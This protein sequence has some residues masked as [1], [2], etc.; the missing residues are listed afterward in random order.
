[1]EVVA[2]GATGSSPAA[3]PERTAGAASPRSLTTGAASLSSLPARV[4]LGLPAL[5][6]LGHVG[7]VYY[8]A[9]SRIGYPFELEWLEGGVLASVQEVLAGRPIFVKP[10]LEY[11]PFLYTPLYDYV[12]AAAA[13]AFGA[14]FTTLRALTLLCTTF[15]LLGLAWQQWRAGEGLG[16]TLLAPGF[17][18]AAFVPTATFYDVARGDVMCVALLF[19]GFLVVRFREGWVAALSG[20]VLCGLAVFTKQPAAAVGAAIGLGV[21]LRRTR[22]GVAFLAAFLVVAGGLCIAEQ[23]RSGGWFSYYAWIVPRGHAI[24][25]ALYLG[26]WTGDL[27]GT[28]PILTLVAACGLIALGVAAARDAGAR[29]DLLFAVALIGSSWAS[30]LHT[31]GWRNVNVAA[32]LALSFVAARWCGRAAAWCARDGRWIPLGALALVLTAHFAMLFRTPEGLIPRAADLADG[33]RLVEL[34]R[35]ERGPVMMM[36]NPYLAVRAGKPATAHGVAVADLIRSAPSPQRDEF[37]AVLRDRLASRHYAMIILHSPWPALD[38]WYEA[39]QEIRYEGAA[40][41]PVNGPENRPALI[42][43]PK[44]AS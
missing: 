13:A 10:S 42:Y 8:V 33:E 9:L 22:D 2:P 34:L 5:L 30:R 23:V 7:F 31:G 4:A 27:L 39:L 44:P 11:V 37:L 18:A 21:L 19:A 40:F 17:F 6:G 14:S 15:V 35:S 29:I 26:F 41:L 36:E 28:S 1:M 3:Q 24:D 20:G 32:F 25:S 43:R 12:G 16:A 38:P